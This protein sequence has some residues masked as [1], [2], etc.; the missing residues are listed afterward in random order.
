M[1][2]NKFFHEEAFIVQHSFTPT[3]IKMKT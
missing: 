2:S 3:R 1:K